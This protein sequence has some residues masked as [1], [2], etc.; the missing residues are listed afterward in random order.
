M[1]VQ[2]RTRKYAKVKRIIGQKD[3]RLYVS[4]HNI[5]CIAYVEGITERR[6]KPKVKSKASERPRA[7]ML[8]G[9]CID[10]PMSWSDIRADHFDSPQVSS[11]L[12]FQV[13]QVPILSLSL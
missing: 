9:K 1:G 5:G 8:C 6:I 10:S 11:S 3:A 2:K 7:M 13:R 4:A 12:F